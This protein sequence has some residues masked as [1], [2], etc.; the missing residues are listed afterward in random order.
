M[1][2]NRTLLVKSWNRRSK[3]NWLIAQSTTPKFFA[4]LERRMPLSLTPQIPKSFKF[5]C[6]HF[7]KP[8]YQFLFYEIF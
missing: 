1:S 4:T 7:L 2:N 3:K 6:Y 5:I 8:S